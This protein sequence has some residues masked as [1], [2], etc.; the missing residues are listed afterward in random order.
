[1]PTLRF[2]ATEGTHNALSDDLAVV[3]N[4]LSVTATT[5]GLTSSFAGGRALEVTANGLANDVIL[6]ET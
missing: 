5:S 4:P 3:Q 6:G 1:M 2:N